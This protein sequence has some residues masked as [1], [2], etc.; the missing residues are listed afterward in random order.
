MGAALQEVIITLGAPNSETGGLSDIARARAQMA[1]REYHSRR[2]CKVVLTG[3]FGPHFN[4]TAKPHS[5]YMAEF[6]RG[7]GI[8][9]SDLIECGT[10]SNTVEDAVHSKRLLDRMP[11]APPLVITSDFHV[12]RATLVF[13][14]VYFPEDLPVLGAAAPLVPKDRSRMEAHEEA[15]CQLLVSQGGVF[16]PVGQRVQLVP[17]R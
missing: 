16:I 2:R 17:L 5:S 11:H 14:A 6:L 8:P 1:L 7:A 4:T 10:S 3:G 13:R 12:R 9:Q 15:G